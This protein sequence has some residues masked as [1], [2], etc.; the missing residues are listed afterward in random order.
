MHP[1]PIRLAGVEPRSCNGVT[2]IAAQSIGV[3]A[4]GRCRSTTLCCGVQSLPQYKKVV[5]V[6]HLEADEESGNWPML[7][8]PGQCCSNLYTSSAGA[9]RE[10][11][12]KRRTCVAPCP[13]RP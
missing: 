13:V 12:P 5:L 1:P 6:C 11:G 9:R 7:E 8:S 10:V 2:R 3:A 4:A